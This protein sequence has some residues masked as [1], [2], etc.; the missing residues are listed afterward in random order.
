MPRRFFDRPS[1]SKRI[2][3]ELLGR[4]DHELLA[5]ERPDLALEAVDLLAHAR[6]DL[7]EALLVQPHAGDLHVAQ[8]AHERQLDLGHQ[9]RQAAVVELLALPRGERLDQ[10]RLGADR[11]GDVARQAALLADLAEREAAAGGL[12]QVGG[13]QRVVD[14]VARHEAQR[15]GVVG[16]DLAVAERG[17]ELLRPVARA[18]EHAVAGR[19]G[20]A[21][22]LGLGE[23]LA[24]AAAPARARRRRPRRRRRARA[25]SA[26]VPPARAR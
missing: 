15:L 19:D 24:L 7:G 9:P 13:E 4:A 11:V 3:A 1:F 10:D 2:C 21:P 20:E 26:S 5:R 12:E 14:E 22:G 17:D 16:D 25:T 23:Q 6:V 8:D 18:D